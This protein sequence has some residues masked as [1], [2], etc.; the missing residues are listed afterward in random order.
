MNDRVEIIKDLK[1][2]LMGSFGNDITEVVLFGSQLNGTAKEHSDY[3]VVVVL[4]N[5]YDWKYRR[6]I[7]DSIYDF[8]LD[9]DIFIDCHIISGNEI[10][11]SLRGVEPLFKDALKDGLYA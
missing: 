5:D 4:K 1:K 9:K 11:N 8:E 3:D 2:H 6:K 7:F 10:K